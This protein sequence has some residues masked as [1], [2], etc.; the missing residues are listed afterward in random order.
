MKEY[1]KYLYEMSIQMEERVLMKT[2]AKAYLIYFRK[3]VIVAII[4]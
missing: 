4:K 3:K 2:Q 1:A